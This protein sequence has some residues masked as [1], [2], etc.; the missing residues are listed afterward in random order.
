M[1][2][3]RRLTS[4]HLR[5]GDSLRAGLKAKG[6]KRRN[7]LADVRA[8][9]PGSMRNDILPKLELVHLNP[10]ELVAPARNV[11]AI[12]PVHVR[13]IM[14]SI[15]TVGFIAPV[16]IDQGNTKRF[17]TMIRENLFMR[18]REVSN[19]SPMSTS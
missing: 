10:N 18:S 6:R 4:Q 11:R 7:A 17:L 15:T 14:N 16:L 2:T 9:G 5:G 8:S 12:D 13:R 3:E 1:T 19:S